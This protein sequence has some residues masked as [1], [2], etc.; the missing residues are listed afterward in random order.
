ML[1][2]CLS[3]VYTKA[4]DA[5]VPANLRILAFGLHTCGKRWPL[6]RSY[7]TVIRAAV[8]EHRSA[9]SGCTLPSE[10]Y[11]PQLCNLEVADL[12]QKWV[13]HSCPHVYRDSGI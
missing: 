1:I 5:D 12:M 11:D 9:V 8:S 4:L 6:A 2:T 13:E 3:T 10:F 7:E